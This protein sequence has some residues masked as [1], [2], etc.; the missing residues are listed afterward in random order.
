[1]LEYFSKEN[2]KLPNIK[3]N[4]S[5][6]LPTIK[7]K[8]PK[9]IIPLKKETDLNLYSWKSMCPLLCQSLKDIC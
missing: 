5:F 2:K 7:I 9:R 8:T 3:S 4:I 6:I 1:M